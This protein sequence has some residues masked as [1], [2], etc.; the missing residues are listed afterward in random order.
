MGNDSGS[1]P[2]HVSE[3]SSVNVASDGDSVSKVN[4]IS[5]PRY[6]LWRHVNKIENNGPNGGNAV[7]ECKFC[8][9]Q[10]SSSYTRIRAYL[11][12]IPNQGVHICKQA[13]I[14]ILQQLRKEVADDEAAISNSKYLICFVALAMA[15]FCH[16]YLLIVLLE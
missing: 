11:L 2:L 14:P 16:F 15:I 10:I 8:G 1:S 5:D 13:T 4:E 12:K 3:P 6:P 9:K 7:I